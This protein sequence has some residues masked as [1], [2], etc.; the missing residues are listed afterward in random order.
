VTFPLLEEQIIRRELISWGV[1]DAQI[2]YLN[3]CTVTHGNLPLAV[4]S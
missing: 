1:L 3:A 4:L 2:I